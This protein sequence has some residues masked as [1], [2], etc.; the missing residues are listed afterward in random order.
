MCPRS[1]GLASG[2]DGGRQRLLEPGPGVGDDRAQPRLLRRPAELAANP[3]ARRDEDRRVT[4][5]P[6]R[7]ERL[8]PA[9]GHLAR[10]LDHL[11]DREA[12]AVAEVVDAV[13]RL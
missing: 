11:A 9:A 1:G 3:L 5:P 10:G 8:D 7:L 2:S 12:R 13:L 4:R 6:R